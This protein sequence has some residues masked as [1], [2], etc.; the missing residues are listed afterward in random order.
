MV[1]TKLS[2]YKT[3]SV[4]TLTQHLI[5]DNKLINQ[6]VIQSVSKSFVQ[7]VNQIAYWSLN[8][9]VVYLINQLEN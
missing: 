6:L 3:V 5:Y 8:Q 9:S 1:Y 7:V 4:E 2:I